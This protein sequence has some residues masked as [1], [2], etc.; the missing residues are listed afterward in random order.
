[1]VYNN[2]QVERYFV[3]TTGIYPHNEYIRVCEFV[4]TIKIIIQYVKYSAFCF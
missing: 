3:V 1:M 2:I 4:N